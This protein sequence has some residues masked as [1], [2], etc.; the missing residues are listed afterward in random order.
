LEHSIKETE[1]LPH[2]KLET[3]RS[4]KQEIAVSEGHKKLSPAREENADSDTGSFQSLTQSTQKAS[5]TSSS[6]SEA[7]TQMGYDEFVQKLDAALQ[8]H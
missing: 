5:S 4:G 3:K 6:G 2:V 7:T 1:A 8:E